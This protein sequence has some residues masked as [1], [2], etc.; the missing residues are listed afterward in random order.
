MKERKEIKSVMGGNKKR[1]RKDR[2]SKREKEKDKK[3]EGF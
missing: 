3:N 2:K 1:A